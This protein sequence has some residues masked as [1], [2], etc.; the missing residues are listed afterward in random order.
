MLLWWAL[1]YRFAHDWMLRWVGQWVRVS[2]EHFAILNFAGMT[3]YKLG[4]FLFNLVPC[5]VLY[6][7]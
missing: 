7:I 6:I 2:S 1:L 5:I 4:I 3:L